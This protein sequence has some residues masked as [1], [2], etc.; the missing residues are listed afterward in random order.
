MSTTP[1]AAQLEQSSGLA[2]M[3]RQWIKALVS[4]VQA[5][6]VASPANNQEQV[7]IIAGELNDILKRLNQLTERMQELETRY[8]VDER[9]SITRG[10]VI[11]LMKKMGI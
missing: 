3:A 7:N 11:A 4:E 6:Q 1:K 8:E 10:K 9:Y 2:P 5:P